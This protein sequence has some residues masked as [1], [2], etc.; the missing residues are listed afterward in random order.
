MCDVGFDSSDTR[1]VCHTRLG[2][3]NCFSEDLNVRCSGSK[4]G[5]F[6]KLKIFS[7]SFWYLYTGNCT[8]G[9]VHLVS[10]SNNGWSCRSMQ[11]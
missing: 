3:H 5:S 7:D 9:D 2:S 10:G 6:L 8:N 1:V 11:K 4:T